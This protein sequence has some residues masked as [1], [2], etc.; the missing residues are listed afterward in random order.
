MYFLFFA[1]AAAATAS[2]LT[3]YITK[4]KYPQEMQQIELK[5]AWYGLT[6][7]CVCESMIKQFIKPFRLLLRFS[8]SPIEPKCIVFING[9][10]DE[11]VR[12]TETEFKQLLLL[13]DEQTRIQK[14]IDYT[15]ILYEFAEADQVEENNKYNRHMLLFDEHTQVSNN[16]KINTKMKL[17]GLC[18]KLKNN[19]N[20][21]FN[22]KFNFGDDNY[23]IVGNKLFTRAYL[24]WLLKYT[25]ASQNLSKNNFSLTHD[26]NYSIAFID[27]RMKCIELTNKQYILIEEDD[28]RLMSTTTEEDKV[29]IL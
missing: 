24:N 13:K 12:H 10:G 22:I 14:G 7:Y 28:Y 21:Q 26:T 16:F 29:S 4:K 25:K 6:T 9:E 5:V 18:M 3:Y 2:A 8:S 1:A 11:I 23:F 20:E 17:L 27:Q 19:N 15:F